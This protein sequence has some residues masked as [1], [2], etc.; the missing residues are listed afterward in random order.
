MLK[1]S[2]L[3]DRPYVLCFKGLE[4]TACRPRPT[5]GAEEGI[6]VLSDRLERVGRVCFVSGAEVILQLTQ[7]MLVD[8]FIDLT[9]IACYSCLRLGVCQTCLQP[10][11]LEDLL[12]LPLSPLLLLSGA[13][14]LDMSI[15]PFG[16]AAFSQL[17]SY[18][19]CFGWWG[20][21]GDSLIF[22][23][24]HQPV[25]LKS[26]AGVADVILTPRHL[27]VGVIKLAD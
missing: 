10:I 25:L 19:I 6:A 4:G 22:I 1:G 17:A 3:A 20:G 8:Q 16:V 26:A 27:E 12:D 18:H 9:R 2:G 14:W 5:L 13:E 21:G 23:G 24:F 15:K 7:P 11:F